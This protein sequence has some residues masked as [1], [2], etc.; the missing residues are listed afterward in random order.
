MH[1]SE[2]NPPSS[3]FFLFCAFEETILFV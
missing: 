2:R 3:K 1:E